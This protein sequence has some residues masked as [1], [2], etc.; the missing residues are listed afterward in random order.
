MVLLNDAGIVMVRAAVVPPVIL[1][2]VE[3]TNP[4]SLYLRKTAVPVCSMGN[5]LAVIVVAC[6]AGN[7][8]TKF[9]KLL[10]TLVIT[11]IVAL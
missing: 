3:V 8:G 7:K 10:V 11:G 6:V 9:A 4:S 2:T 5:K 1:T